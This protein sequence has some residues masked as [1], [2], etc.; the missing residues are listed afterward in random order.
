VSQPKRSTFRAQLTGTL[1]DE[2]LRKSSE[3]SFAIAS[4]HQLCRR[5]NISRVTVRLALSDLEAKGLIYRIHG[6]GTFAYGRPKRIRRSIGVLLKS[7]RTMSSWPITEMIRGMESMMTSLHVNVLLMQSSPVEWSQELIRDLSAILVIPTA[8]TREDID[9]LRNSKKP[10]LFSWETDLPGPSISFRQVEAA[11]VATERLLLLGHE[12]IVL[13]TGCEESMDGLKRQGV[14][15]AFA[16]VGK[17]PADVVEFSTCG[18]STRTETWANLVNLQPRP[19]AVICCDDHLAAQLIHRLR[20][21]ASIRIPEDISVVSFHKSPYLDH[22]G[23]ELSTVDFN[24]FEAGRQAATS[25]NRAALTGASLED[26]ELQT[27][28]SLGRSTARPIIQ[29]DVSLH[30]ER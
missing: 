3:G 6:K 24:F 13:V 11:R 9:A 29:R 10:Y 18:A 21:E 5:F 12:R 7:P 14:R 22:L 26:I 30:L 15:D 17:S 8:V 4:E 20:H 19:T 16:S 27:S 25:L 1:A 23:P 2:I 28:H